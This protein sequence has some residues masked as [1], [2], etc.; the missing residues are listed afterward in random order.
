MCFNIFILSWY[1]FTLHFFYLQKLLPGG[2]T[3]HSRKTGVRVR[4]HSRCSSSPSLTTL[5]LIIFYWHKIIPLYTSL[6]FCLFRA[7]FAY[8]RFSCGTLSNQHTCMGESSGNSCSL[9]PLLT[10]RGSILTPGCFF[11][12][13]SIKS[14]DL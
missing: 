13:T 2:F 10:T 1:D 4:I 14:P 11:A 3:D 6:Y 12:H 7:A 8:P 9:S 5:R